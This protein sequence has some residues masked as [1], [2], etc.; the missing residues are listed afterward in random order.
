MDIADIDISKTYSYADYLT[1]RFQERVELLKGKLFKMSPA[2][3]RQHQ[4]ISRNLAT[5]LGVHF[6]GKTC[7]YYAAPFD[8]RLAAKGE[9]NSNVLTVVQPDLCVICDPSKLDER[10]CIGTPDWIIEILSPGNS[11][12]EMS[13]KYKIYEEAGV[14]EYWLVLPTE[15]TVLVYVLQD[16]KFIGMPPATEDDQLSPAIFPEL[17]INLQRVFHA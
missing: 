12:K 9:G 16:G 15:S 2:P 1:W 17:T 14:R 13:N 7:E 8:V 6:E 11:K 10:G 4:K 3:S 5:A